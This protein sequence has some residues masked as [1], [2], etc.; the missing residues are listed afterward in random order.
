MSTVQNCLSINKGLK[1]KLTVIGTIS[2]IWLLEVEVVQC[3][4]K[5]RVNSNWNDVLRSL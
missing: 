2:F 4:Q 1:I 3:V 5:T